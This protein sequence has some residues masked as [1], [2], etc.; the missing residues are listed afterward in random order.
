M[1]KSI[2]KMKN[3]LLF[4]IFTWIALIPIIFQLFPISPMKNR[5]QCTF[6]NIF[7]SIDNQQAT[8]DELD[9]FDFFY[10]KNA[11]L[12]DAVEQL[13]LFSAN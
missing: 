6:S 8:D 2:G 7:N 1:P 3:K 9:A 13:L 11:I 5:S 4:K 10:T 12:W